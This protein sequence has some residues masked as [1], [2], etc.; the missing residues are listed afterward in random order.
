MRNTK[1]VSSLTGNSRRR[2]EREAERNGLPLPN[3][4]VGRPRL[5]EEVKVERAAEKDRLKEAWIRSRDAELARKT[6]IQELD[7]TTS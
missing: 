4:K 5:T 3:F 7:A 1:R 6:E 2:L